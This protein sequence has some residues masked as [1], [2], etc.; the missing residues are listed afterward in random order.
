MLLEKQ[1]QENRL[2]IF[3]EGVQSRPSNYRGSLRLWL[4]TVSSFIYIF[5][6]ETTF[7]CCDSRLEQDSDESAQGHE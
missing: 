1:G 5:I 7:G 3:S 2:R 4:G 6:K